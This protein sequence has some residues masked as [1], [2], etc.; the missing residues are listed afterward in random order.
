MGVIVDPCTTVTWKQCISVNYFWEHCSQIVTRM[1]SSRMRTVPNVD[2]IPE[3][4]IV[5]GGGQGGVKWS[6]GVVPCLVLGGC[7]VPGGVPAWSQG[8]VLSWGVYLPGPGGRGV[9]AWSGGCTCLV[10]GDTCLEPGG[11]YLPETRGS[12]F[13]QADPPLGHEFLDRMLCENITLA[14]TLFRPVIT[15]GLCLI[16]PS[17]PCHSNL[18][19]PEFL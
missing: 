2:R 15:L 18:S 10:Q 12:H 11:V 19:F 17:T 5:S 16:L 4:A 3:S 13:G 9:P 1:H 6:Q 14:K 7:L 8:G